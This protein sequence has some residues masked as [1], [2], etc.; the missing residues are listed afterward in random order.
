MILALGLL[1]SAGITVRYRK[2]HLLVFVTN[3]LLCNM[4]DRSPS[5]SIMA[6]WMVRF[7]TNPFYIVVVI[8]IHN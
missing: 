2:N 4:L 8:D 1:M 5:A 7:C 6:L 3:L